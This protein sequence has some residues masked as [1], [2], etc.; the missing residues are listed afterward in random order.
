MALEG[1]NKQQPWVDP[2]RLKKI[3]DGEEDLYH[4][5]DRLHVS[6]IDIS[7]A[8]FN[9]KTK[10]D[11]PVYVELPPEDP[12]YGEGLC[13]QLRAHVRNQTCCRWVAL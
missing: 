13:G 7:R 4:G 3:N 5:D 8:Y 1:Q 6:M 11:D 9:A 10:E 12:D 2:K